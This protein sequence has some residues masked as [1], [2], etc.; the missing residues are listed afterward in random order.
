IWARLLT[1]FDKDAEHAR[2]PRMTLNSAFL[3][4]M[5]AA[6]LLFLFVPSFALGMAVFVVVMVLELGAYLVL[7]AQ[8][9]GLGDLGKQFKGFLKGFGKKGSKEPKLAEGEVM[10]L[11]KKGAPFMPPDEESPDQAAYTAAQAMF[12]DA[13]RRGAERIEMKPTDGAASVR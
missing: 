2:L 8:K 7:R 4:G 11:D 12:T 10:L 1:W 5:V 6:F 9:I 3:P 13:L